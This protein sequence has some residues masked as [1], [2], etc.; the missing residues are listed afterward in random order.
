MQK[1]FKKKKPTECAQAYRDEQCQQ[2]IQL[3][4]KRMR[5]SNIYPVAYTEE[6][7][8]AGKRLHL[9][10]LELKKKL[11]LKTEIEF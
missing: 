6:E 8:K 4:V 3:I 9:N 5:Q 7:N 11:K 1:I 10:F 2:E